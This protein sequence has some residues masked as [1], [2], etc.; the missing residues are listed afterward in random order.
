[1]LRVIIISLSC[2]WTVCL[3]IQVHAEVIEGKFES[4]GHQFQYEGLSNLKYPF[5]RLSDEPLLLI[6]HSSQYWDARH[7]T[8]P[9]ITL[10]VSFFRNH[11]LPLK[12]M[13][14]IEERGAI[15]D[16]ASKLANLY[17]PPGVTTQDIYPYQGDSHRI[18]TLGQ[19]IVIAGG[20]FTICACNTA[21]SAIALSETLKP[22]HIHYAMD[23]IYEGQMGVQLKL[24]EISNRL[25]DVAFLRYLQDQYFNQ[26]T[27]PCKE[28]SLYALDR[29][30]SY[31]I[32]RSGKW[33]G[34]YGQGLTPVVLHF[35]NSQET[36][37]QLGLAE[38]EYRGF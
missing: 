24:L 38:T 17:F 18:I 32:Y 4:G 36:L 1:M 21:R 23:A 3:P 34:R 25:D 20:N 13:A 33:I 11:N 22:L 16:M 9:G 15:N 19:H 6:T 28:P 35:E 27:L 37:R 5:L 8:W 29:Q 10:L 30:F 14:A 2:L 12:Y 7:I 31:E 26:D